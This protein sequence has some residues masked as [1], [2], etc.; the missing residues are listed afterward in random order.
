[1][2]VGRQR[3]IQLRKALF[4]FAGEPTEAVEPPFQFFALGLG[5][6]NGN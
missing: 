1:V 2:G 4:L 6:E 3:G 5:D